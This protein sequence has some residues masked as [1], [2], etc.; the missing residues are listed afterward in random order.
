MM[1]ASSCPLSRL[2]ERGQELAFPRK[3]EG[4]E[5]GSQSVPGSTHEFRSFESLRTRSRL[6]NHG[7]RPSTPPQP[8]STV[9]RRQRPVCYLT[10]PVHLPVRVHPYPSRQ[11]PDIRLRIW[12]NEPI[13]Q[14]RIHQIPVRRVVMRIQERVAQ[15]PRQAAHE[16]TAL[17]SRAHSAPNGCGG[18]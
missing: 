3:D 14:Q 9:V 2:G 6:S 11:I 15:A 8:A 13:R 10:Q 4:C 1:E 7:Q 16:H 17:P 5:G 18:G 12:H